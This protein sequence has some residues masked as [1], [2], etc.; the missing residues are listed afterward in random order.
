M[1][2]SQNM[3]FITSQILNYIQSYTTAYSWWQKCQMDKHA[4]F[5][6]ASTSLCRT[7]LEKEWKYHAAASKNSD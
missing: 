7:V 1:T 6:K 3:S 4:V 5:S 2:K